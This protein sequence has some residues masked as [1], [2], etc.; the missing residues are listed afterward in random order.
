MGARRRKGRF[1]SGWLVLDKP[2][3]IGSTPALGRARRIFDAQK[4]GHAGTLDPLASGILPVAFGEATKTI[5]MMMDASKTYECT[6]R[7]GAT[8]TTDDLEGEIV[9]Q[10]A[11]RPDDSA[12]Q[13]VLSRF[14]GEISQKPPVYSAL[15]IDGR[16]AYDMAR[17]GEEP[18]LAL[19]QVRIDHIEVI[20]RPDADHLQLR[21]D[22]GKGTYIRALGRDIA[23]ELGSLGHICALRRTRVGNF[24]LDHAIGL[25]KLMDLGHSTPDLNK[26]DRLIL[27]LETVL[28]DIPALALDENQARMVRHG[29]SIPV[30]DDRVSAD[31]FW[32]HY[33]TKAVALGTLRE[34]VFKPSRIINQS[35]LGVNEM[36]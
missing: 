14:T 8:T 35:P 22:C 19:R 3:G 26:L 15:K 7:F 16:R 30:S 17:A 23:Q 6:I 2:V 13:M 36:E 4:A 34:S 10:T 29:Q 27:P 33:E 12:I 20:A 9:N 25:E 1:F 18:D 5:H 28:D 24:S 21:V 11:V 32:V 31:I